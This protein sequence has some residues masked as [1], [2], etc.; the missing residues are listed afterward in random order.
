MVMIVEAVEKKVQLQEMTKTK[1]VVRAKE[2]MRVKR[3]RRKN[4]NSKL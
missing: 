2:A 4:N 3:S 1:K